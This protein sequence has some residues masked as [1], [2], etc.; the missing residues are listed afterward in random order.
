MNLIASRLSQTRTCHKL[1]FLLEQKL[2]VYHYH[3]NYSRMSPLIPLLISLWLKMSSYIGP[4]TKRNTAEQKTIYEN[5]D[6]ILALEVSLFVQI[7]TKIKILFATTVHVLALRSIEVL[8]FCNRSPCD[9]SPIET[10]SES[11]STRHSRD[12]VSIKPCT[13]MKK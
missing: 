9:S 1:P 6:Q 13:E 10:G 8:L 5:S 4:S 2:M 3:Y 12:Q 11:H 7:K